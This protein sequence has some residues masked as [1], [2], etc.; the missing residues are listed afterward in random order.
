LKQT[1]LKE[2][3]RI[4][5]SHFPSLILTTNVVIKWRKKAFNL[6]GLHSF[7]S[8]AAALRVRTSSLKLQLTAILGLFQRSVYS[9]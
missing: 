1:V 6:R 4:N 7:R 2:P 9:C 8:Q 5:E 3:I